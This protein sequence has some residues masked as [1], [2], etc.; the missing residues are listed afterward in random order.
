MTSR[1]IIKYAW[2][3]IKEA[4]IKKEDFFAVMWI[5]KWGRV[6]WSDLC[7]VLSNKLSYRWK[8]WIMERKYRGSW[9]IGIMKNG[10]KHRLT[11][12]A[13]RTKENGALVNDYLWGHTEGEKRRGRQRLKTMDDIERRILQSKKTD[14]VGT[15]G[16]KSAIL[17]V[18]VSRKLWNN[19]IR[20]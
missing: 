12:W 17:D 9:N 13:V 18:P 4:F 8:T 10:E 3:F 2:Y 6:C 5:W 19:H 14:M 16:D 15:V 20:V 7:I 11:K 1:F